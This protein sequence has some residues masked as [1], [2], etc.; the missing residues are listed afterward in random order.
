ML[1]LPYPGYFPV[2]NERAL[3]RLISRAERDSAF[4]RELESACARR[5]PL[6]SIEHEKSALDNLIDEL[7][8]RPREL[9]QAAA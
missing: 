2:G 8:P 6:I 4:Y 1:G 3:A 7:T 5:A 9:A